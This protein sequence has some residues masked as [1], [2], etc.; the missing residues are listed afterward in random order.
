MEIKNN[1]DF[2][3]YLKWDFSSIFKDYNGNSR[4]LILSPWVAGFNNLRMSLELA[5]SIAYLNNRTLILPPPYKIPTHL[6]NSEEKNGIEDYFELEEALGIK[7]LSFKDFCSIKNINEDL[8]SAKKISKVLNYDCVKNVLNFEKVIPP[9]DFLKSRT[10]INAQDYFTDE[11]CIFL[12]KNLLGIPEQTIYTSLDTEIKKLIAKH[13]RYKKEIFDI[14]S[15]FINSLKDKSYYAIHIRRGDHPTQYKQ[16]AISSE[17]I[18]ENIKDIIPFGS[19]LYIATD[20]KDENFFKIFQ[21]NYEVYFYKDFQNIIEEKYKNIKVTWIPLIEQ[22]ICSRSIKFVGNKLSTL[23]SLIYRIRGYME[24]IEDKNYYVNTEKFEK[25][26]QCTFLEDK[27]YTANW[28]RYYKDSWNFN[29]EK[30]FVSIASFCDTDVINTIKSLIEKSFDSE[31]ICIGLH[32]QDDEDFYKK[33]LSYNFKN[34]RIKFTPKELTKG[35][36]WARNK[37]KEEL[38]NNEDYFLQIDSHSRVKKNWDNILINQYK[39]FGLQKIVLSTYPNH[40]DLPD[41]EKKYL[42]VSN[43]A[44]LKVIGFCNDDANDNRLK[45]ANIDSLKDYEM[46]NAYWIAAGFFFTNRQWIKE[47]TYSDL[48]TCKGE[49]DIMTLLSYLKGWNLRVTSEATVW[50]NYSF[51]FKEPTDKDG[52]Q[53]PTTGKAYRVGN[54]GYFLKDKSVKLINHYLFEYKYDKSLEDLEDYFNIKLKKPENYKTSSKEILNT[55]L[56]IDK[57]KNSKPKKQFPKIRNF[58]KNLTNL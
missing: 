43:N 15:E 25:S 23:S 22:L 37:I 11:E 7:Y 57:I 28:A 33:I 51:K 27:H 41:D 40:F 6:Y 56:N 5:V 3:Y 17:A 44:P 58:N 39:S 8:E 35:V 29:K 34:L 20:H 54:S 48:I 38:Y 42:S 30:I 13:I 46:V 14:A 45:V 50:H 32:L 52:A 24:D 19:K 9:K 4:Y 31:R 12:D 18:I 16:L 55:E 10:Y 26:K 47:I 36:H 2:L 21:E 53:N 49:E 1:N